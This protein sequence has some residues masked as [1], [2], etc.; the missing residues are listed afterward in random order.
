MSMN[1]HVSSHL[2][3][4]K[5]DLFWM[6]FRIMGTLIPCCSHYLDPLTDLIRTVHLFVYRFINKLLTLWKHY[7]LRIHWGVNLIIIFLLKFYTDAS[8]LTWTDTITNLA[9][10]SR[11][12][13]KTWEY[14]AMKFESDWL[15]HIHDN[16]DEFASIPL[17]MLFWLQLKTSLPVLQSRIHDR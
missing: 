5:F 8:P 4:I 15:A 16:G 14:I 12:N 6:Q 11:I 1:L 7:W 17:H 3:W 10:I 2:T 13:N 9:G